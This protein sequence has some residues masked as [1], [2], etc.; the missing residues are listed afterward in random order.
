MAAGDVAV[1]NDDW[2][3]PRIHAGS[4]HYCEEAL[5]TLEKL[6]VCC[7]IAEGGDDKVQM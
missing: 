2:K 7:S 6:K 5:G 3:F 4:L 1:V